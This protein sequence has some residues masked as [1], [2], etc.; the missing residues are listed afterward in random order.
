MGDPVINMVRKIVA[1]FPDVT[2]IF[3][4]CDLVRANHRCV[5]SNHKSD[6][7]DIAG[8]VPVSVYTVNSLPVSVYTINSLPLLYLITFP[9]FEHLTTCYRISLPPFLPPSYSL[10]T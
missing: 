1:T 8:T 6:R 7:K 4:N 9:P 2:C 10:V 3:L 5:L